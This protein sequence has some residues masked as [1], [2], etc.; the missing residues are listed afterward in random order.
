LAVFW[1][2]GGVFSGFCVVW[3]WYNTVLGGFLL[4]NRFARCFSMFAGICECL[5]ELVD[6]VILCLVYLVVVCLLFGVLE[7]LRCFGFV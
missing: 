2:L 3:G 5:G 7:M 1:L 6:F 4:C